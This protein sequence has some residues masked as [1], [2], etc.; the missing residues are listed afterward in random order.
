[1]NNKTVLVAGN[2]GCIGHALTLRLLKDGYKVIGIDD[3]RRRRDVQEMKSFSATPIKYMNEKIEI[4]KEIGDFTFYS[5]SM[6]MEY[7]KLKEIFFLHK[8]DTVVNLAQQPSA[9][10]SQKSR[11]HAVETTYGNLIGTL[12]VLYAI[13]ETVPNTQLIQIGSMGEYNPAL[14]I[15]I[16]E[17]IFD[18]KHDG[19][20]IKNAIFPRLPGSYYHASKV[21]STYYIDCACRWW[22]L[23]ATDIMQGPV[24]GNWTPEIEEFNLHTRL[25]S[26]EC[27][28]TVAN[29]F[30]VQALLNKPLTIY[31]KGD[32]KRGFLSLN[33]S[34]QCLMLAIENKPKIG[35]YRT[36]N[37][38][39]KIYSM[40]E[41]AE[42]VSE[43]AIEYG[44]I[45]KINTIHIDTSR[46][47]RTD[48]FLYNPKVDK[49]NKLGFKPTRSIKDESLY[50]FKV[51]SNSIDELFP[52][53]DVIDPK[54]KWRI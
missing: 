34:V 17:G 49:L 33:D 43:A 51:L 38:L 2:D 7:D 32:H 14:G 29:R 18:F 23:N 48:D 16:P 39:S 3:F 30:I 46:A 52:L 22:D 36:W 54:I 53:I 4:F 35:E 24:F 10:F 15:E 5:N 21:A 27:F 37:Q 25:D 28:G 6:E 19:I 26:D 41:V 40:N 31:G 12:N 47:E 42:E 11:R 45:D 1:M 13:K 50:A 44:I 20:E 8:P 9:P